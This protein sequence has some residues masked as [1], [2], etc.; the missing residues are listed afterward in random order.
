M[1]VGRELAGKSSG[2]LPVT[3]GQWEDEKT[4][5]MEGKR[6]TLTS[7][8]W[9]VGFRT[10]FGRFDWNDIWGAVRPAGDFLWMSTQ[11][12]LRF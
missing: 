2:Q 10:N 11:P 4:G 9:H 12:N 1:R 8:R 3:S 5:R 6:Y 7:S